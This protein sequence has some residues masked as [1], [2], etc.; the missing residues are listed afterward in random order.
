[1]FVPYL[2]MFLLLYLTCSFALPSP[3]REKG[4]TTDARESTSGETL[5]EGAVLDLKEFYFLTSRRQWFFWLLATTSGTI[6][7]LGS[8]VYLYYGAPS[9]TALAAGVGK[10]LAVNFIPAILAAGLA[11]TDRWW[12]HAIGGALTPVVMAASMAAYLP[13]SAP[14]TQGP[15]CEFPRASHDSHR[16]R[17]DHQGKGSGERSSRPHFHD[18]RGPA[19]PEQQSDM[20]FSMSD[21]N[22]RQPR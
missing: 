19:H 6:G 10:T 14:G 3:N 15:A 22:E 9:F 12:L 2:G 11:L 5:T 8:G 13:P 21:H 20:L 7:L 16:K 17:P 18:T 1:M 4:L